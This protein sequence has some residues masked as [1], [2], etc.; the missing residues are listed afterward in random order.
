MIP[1]P[2]VPE[3]NLFLNRPPQ[4]V[5]PVTAQTLAPTMKPTRTIIAITTAPARVASSRG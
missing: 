5:V 2:V 4:S 3:V 1:I